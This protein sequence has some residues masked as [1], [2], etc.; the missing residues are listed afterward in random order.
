[1][2]FGRTVALAVVVWPCIGALSQS[3][4]SCGGAKD[5]LQNMKVKLSPDPIQ[6]GKPFTVDVSGDLDEDIVA[7][8]VNVDL[9]IT[10]LGV[11]KSSVKQVVPFTQTPGLSKGHFKLSI[12]PS[13]IP[14]IPGSTLV[15]GRVHLVDGKGEAVF[16]LDLNIHV[17]DAM[18]ENSTHEELEVEEQS[19]VTAPTHEELEVEEKSHVT[20]PS[21]SSVAS[22]SK[23]TDHL[24]DARISSSGG[25]TKIK[26][27]LDESLS[28][29]SVDLDIKIKV[30]FVSIPLKLKIPL[31]I[32]PAFPK[33]A[34]GL[35]MG[36]VSGAISPDPHAHVK[37]TA[38]LN[39]ANAEE[40]TCLKLD[41]VSEDTASKVIV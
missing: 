14:N 2:M 41:V 3:V 22:C 33:G 7:G 25:V 8:T 30:L 35:T 26:G 5:H 16:C 40:I 38:V 24:K 15:Q 17:G 23:A 11:I 21:V 31:S 29:L 32:S 34:F 1:M 20:A 6:K 9:S 19:H 39:D 27:T 10:A 13:T 18:A 12:G 4:K 37:G 28:K 36:P